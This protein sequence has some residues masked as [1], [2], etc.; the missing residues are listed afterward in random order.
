METSRQLCYFWGPE[1]NWDLYARSCGEFILTPPDEEK[2]RKVDFGEIFWPISGQCQFRM[3]GKT[4]VVHPGN[5]WYYPPGSF[6]DYTPLSS[7]HYCWLT[8]A[9]ERSGA[10]FDL[11]KIVPGLNRAGSCPRNLF[12]QLGA[13]IDFHSAKHRHSAISTA[14][15]I[16]SQ[17]TFLPKTRERSDKSMDSIKKMIEQSFDNPELSVAHL[18]ETFHLHRGSF[19]RAFRKN[20]GMTVCDYITFIRLKN[21]LDML[22]DSSVS[23]R[24]IAEACGFVSANYFSKVFAAHFGNTPVKYR[25]QIAARI[26]KQG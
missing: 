21:A 14:F 19:S 6:H 5:V 9:G 1:L 23:I 10:F 8:V 2:K 16:V 25:K 4:F 12:T 18:A 17:V 24:D 11:L 3:N 22:A 26:V 20:T 7:F 13:E 15:K